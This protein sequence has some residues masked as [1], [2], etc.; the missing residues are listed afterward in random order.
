MKFSLLFVNPLPSRLSWGKAV[1][2]IS[3]VLQPNLVGG[4][5]SIASASEDQ[6]LARAR[7]LDLELDDLIYSSALLSSERNLILPQAHRMIFEVLPIYSFE[8]FNG[9][10][11]LLLEF[12]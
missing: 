7:I 9:R 1:E 10:L 4:L 12:E 2:L 8:R 5:M 3:N 6:T 11:H